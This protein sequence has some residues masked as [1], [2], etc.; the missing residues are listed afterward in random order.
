MKY[1]PR[2]YEDMWEMEHMK[3]K[4]IIKA[5]ERLFYAVQQLKLF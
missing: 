3:P 1:A 5:L 4:Q 2:N